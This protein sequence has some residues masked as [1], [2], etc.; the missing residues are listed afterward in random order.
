MD[1]VSIDLDSEMDEDDVGDD[2]GETNGFVA[3][4]LRGAEASIVTVGLVIYLF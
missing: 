3:I 2:G 4:C 1:A